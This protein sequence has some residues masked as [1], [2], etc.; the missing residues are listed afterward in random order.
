MNWE[1]YENHPRNIQARNTNSFRIQ[2]DY[3]TQLSQ[4]I[5]GRVTKKLSQEFSKAESRILAALS[6]LDD[7]LLKF[8]LTPDPFR[9]HLGI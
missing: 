6:R 2:E 7:F 1:N 9:R 4:D 3:F 5:E 8:R